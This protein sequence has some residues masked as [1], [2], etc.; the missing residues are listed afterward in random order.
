M[1]KVEY[2]RH[3]EN[4]NRKLK[5]GVDNLRMESGHFQTVLGDMMEQIYSDAAAE[6]G[7][8]VLTNHTCY[9]DFVGILINNGYSVCIEPIEH[10]AKLRI[11]ILESE[12]ED[13]ANE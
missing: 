11:S 8:V 2:I 4:E 13:E 9:Q 10:G 5:Q 7:C 6:C 12:S 3:L 1:G